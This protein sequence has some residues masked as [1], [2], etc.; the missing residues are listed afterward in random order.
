MSTE[1]TDLLKVSLNVVKPIIIGCSGGV[2][3]LFVAKRKPTL[4]ALASCL[5]VS[6]FAGW[7]TSELCNALGIHG[8]WASVAVGIG[9]FYGPYTLTSLGKLVGDKLGIDFDA[10]HEDEQHEPEPCD[11]GEVCDMPTE[12]TVP[13]DPKK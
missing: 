4:A 1:A 13:S 3:A 9:G 2:A 12:I 7:L 5:F 10:P 6:G 11:S 8:S